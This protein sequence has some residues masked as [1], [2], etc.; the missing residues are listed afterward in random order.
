MTLTN[1][2][3]SLFFGIYP[4]PQPVTSPVALASKPAF[5]DKFPTMQPKSEPILSVTL[6]TF[7]KIE[8]LPGWLTDDELLRDEGVFFGLSDARPDGKIAQIRASFAQ[9]AALLE[10][11]I[12]QHTEK[13]TEL[14]LLI[15]QREN[16]II[17]LRDQITDLRDNQP[18]P[19][20]LIR[21]VVSLVLSVVMCI[22]N[23][24]LIDVT[25]QPSFPNRWI[26]VGVFL[27]GMFNLFGR[28]SFFYETGSQLSRRRIVEEVGLPLAASIFVLVQS[29][30]TQAVGPAMGLFVFVFF[31]FLLSGKLLLS[32]LS[33]L[34]GD[35]AVIQKN[36]RLAI[37]KEQ[38]LPVWEREIERFEREVDAIR[39]QKWPIV[40]A[41]SHAEA[42]LNQLNAQRD[43]LVNVFLSEFEL[44]RSL[45]E[46]LTDQQ[47]KLIMNYDGAPAR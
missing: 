43:K 25:L 16:N 36:Q 35:L 40:T 30:Q 24:Y 45:R 17:S 28:T 34:Q 42:G 14:N 22:S 23:F 46:K 41:L 44:A 21:T 47:R 33:F 1:R 31:V 7:G 2:L 10:E 11:S 8:S 27:A 18:A 19:T 3:R 6:P 9:Q 5:M 32:T 13:I 15:Q 39:A 20:N 4:S 37:S 26:A 38:N 29:L 12:E